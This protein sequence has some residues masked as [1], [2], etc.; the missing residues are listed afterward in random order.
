[1]KIALKNS[2]TH[3]IV[4]KV[5]SLLLGY[6]LWT[7]IANGHTATR[8]FTVPLCFYG[9]HAAL[10]TAPSELTVTLQAKRTD[11]RNIQTSTL[12]IHID[13]H[14]LHPGKNHIALDNKSL[15]LPNAIKLVNYRPANIIVELP[16]HKA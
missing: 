4:L 2:L 6:G 16:E 3:T 5:I 15:F 9:E 13:T 12:G 8:S 10:V 7:I 1:M 14:Q 11:L